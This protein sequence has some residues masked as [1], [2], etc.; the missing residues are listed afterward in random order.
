ME[1]DT[2]GQYLTEAHTVLQDLIE[3]YR[4]PE[5]DLARYLGMAFFELRRVRPDLV[6]FSFRGTLPTFTSDDTGK[7]VTVPVDP[8]YRGPVLNYVL[9][10]AQIRDD[11]N[12]QDSRALAV[13]NMFYQQLKSV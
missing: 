12:N 2:V 5:A 1:L 8:M 7:T 10:M 6:M 4:Y 13:L 11:E 9:G 3:P